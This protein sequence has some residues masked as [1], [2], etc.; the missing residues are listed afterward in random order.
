M[1]HGTV[2]W[3]NGMVE[4]RNGQPCIFACAH[5]T[6]IILLYCMNFREKN[7]VRDIENDYREAMGLKVDSSHTARST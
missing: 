3:N 6:G 4:W 7:R 2:E 5:Y 1:E